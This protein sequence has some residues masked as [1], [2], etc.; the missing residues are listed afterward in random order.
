MTSCSAPTPVQLYWRSV[1]KKACRLYL[2]M[3]QEV[4]E[5]GD[6]DVTVFRLSEA[7]WQALV[8]GK[9]PEQWEPLPFTLSELAVHPE[10]ATFTALGITE[11]GVCEK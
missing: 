9:E 8:D 11:T 6:G 10:F 7:Q 5:L 2:S 3:G 4:R 1:R